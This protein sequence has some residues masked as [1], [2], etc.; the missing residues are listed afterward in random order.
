MTAQTPHPSIQPNVYPSAPTSPA[1][2]PM[3]V[4][5]GQYEDDL[6]LGQILQI[7]R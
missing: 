5:F 1:A 2:A 3:P 6:D 7:L 4:A